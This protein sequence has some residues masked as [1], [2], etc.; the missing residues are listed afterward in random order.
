MNKRERSSTQSSLSG[1]RT[2]VC[3]SYLHPSNVFLTDIFPSTIMVAQCNDFQ[4][5]MSPSRPVYP[6][7]TDP[8]SC[9]L[10]PA[11][12]PF[13]HSLLSEQWDHQYRTPFLANSSCAIMECFV[14]YTKDD[15]ILI[16][17][18]L[19]LL[20][21]FTMSQAGPNICSTYMQSSRYH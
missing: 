4:S 20:P 11:L 8:T 12:V 9:Y 10:S 13:P 5:E 17:D 7:S 1:N 3:F 16:H 14:S 21:Y 18:K 6:V 15:Q 19:L 2:D